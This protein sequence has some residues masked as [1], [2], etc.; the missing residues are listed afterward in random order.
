MMTATPDPALTRQLL[1]AVRQAGAVIMNFYALPHPTLAVA[2]K[3]DQSPVTA[4]DLAAHH[5]LLEQLHLLTPNLPVISEEDEDS[6]ADRL[7]HERYWLIDP[8]DGTREFISGSGEFTVNLAL[9]DH[10]TPVW[11]C[12]YAP[13]LEQMYWGGLGLGAFRCE[14]GMTAEMQVSHGGCNSTCRVVASKSHMDAET[15]EFIA[16]L[17]STSLVQAG[18]SLKFCRIA[19]GHAD[20][21]P[22]M[23]PTCEWDTAAAQAVLEGAGGTVHD[24]WDKPLTYGKAN[25]LNPSFIARRPGV[26]WK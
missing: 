13:A 25:I 26:A 5:V 3:S 1:D 9:I 15:A 10:K 8:L 24:L 21:Y 12:V 20:I 11:G 2:K 4:A 14:H 18:S 23:G 19:E 16:T 7:G 22:R 6:F 17:G